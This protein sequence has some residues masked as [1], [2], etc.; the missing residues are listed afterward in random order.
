[1]K[2]FIESKQDIVNIYLLDHVNEAKYYIATS[3]NGSQ[4]KF[5]L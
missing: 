3:F 2:F 5:F 4:I 1:M